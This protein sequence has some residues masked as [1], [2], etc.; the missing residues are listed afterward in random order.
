MAITPE[1]W[2]IRRSGEETSSG[3][4][5]PR[6]PYEHDRGRVLHSFAFRRLEA[7]TQVLGIA[8]SDFHRSRLTH[9]MEVAGIARGIVLGLRKE[10]DD[11]DWSTDPHELRTLPSLDLI[12]AICFCHDLGHP[13][14]GHSGERALNYEMRDHGGFEGNGHSL[15]LI[16][17]LEARSGVYGLDLTRRTMLGI[18]KYPIP[19]TQAVEAGAGDMTEGEG[20]V[21][22]PAAELKPPKCYLD[23]EKHVVD[24]M[25]SVLS[26]EDRDRFTSYKVHPSEGKPKYYHSF[27]TS[28]MELADDIAY[29]VHDLEDGIVLGLINKDQWGEAEEK[30]DA[31]WAQ[32]HGLGTFED[33]TTDLFENGSDERKK[34]VGAL[35]NAFVTSSELTEDE[36]FECAYLRHNVV[37]EGPGRELLGALQDVTADSIIM[38]YNVQTLRHR[39]RFMIR[40]LFK[41]IASNPDIYLTPPFRRLYKEAVDE[42]GRKRVICDY[43][44]G[45]TDEYATRVYER[46]Y[47]PREGTVFDRL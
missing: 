31:T 23:G 37:L 39:G 7:K 32:N 38:S 18:L 46:F 2:I 21:H 35:V 25:L 1:D 28:I 19:F 13:P 14:F 26:Q 6:S 16:S 22:D 27:S 4:Q 41:A 42:R 40:R 34:T 9:T 8:E 15:R 17:R 3:D 45:M 30:Y 47:T 5:D 44:A 20:E 11:E 24:W 12:D 33:L 36:G 10:M 43:I 29:G